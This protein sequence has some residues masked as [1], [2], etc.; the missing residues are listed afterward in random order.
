M[1]EHISHQEERELTSMASGK[2]CLLQTEEEF[3]L[4]AEQKEEKN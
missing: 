1:K 4:H 3:C 2:E